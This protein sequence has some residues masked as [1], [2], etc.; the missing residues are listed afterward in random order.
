[1]CASVQTV[2]EFRAS[3]EQSLDF[4]HVHSV[5]F[6][7]YWGATSPKMLHCLQPNVYKSKSLVWWTKPL[8]TK[9]ICERQQRLAAFRRS[10]SRALLGVQLLG[11]SAFLKLKKKLRLHLSG[12]AIK[13]TRSTQNIKWLSAILN[14][15]G[16]TERS[17]WVTWA[18]ES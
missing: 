3:E 2:S 11:R 7:R 6:P 4:L 14:C 5:W 1:M 9:L 13:T 15:H 18:Y 16:N 8:K 10:G 17:A 12:A